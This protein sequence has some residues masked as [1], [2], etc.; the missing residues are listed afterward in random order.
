MYW[1]QGKLYQTNTITLAIDEPGLLYGATIF[2]T[3]RVYG[4]SLSHRLTHWQAHGD[5]LKQSIM[6]LGWRS[7][8]WNHIYQGAVELSKYFPVVR[9]TLFPDGREWI[10]GR[11]LP[12]DLKTKQQQGIVATVAHSSYRRSLPQLKTGNYLTPWLARKEAIQK[13]AGEA[14][15]T[16]DDG[17]WLETSTGNLWGYRD[18]CWWTPQL[19]NILPGIIREYLMQSISV[20]QTVWTPSFVA[21]IKTLAYSNSVV[22]LMPIHTVITNNH[23]LQFNPAHTSLKQL[24]KISFLNLKSS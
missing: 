4:G 12:T 24:F 8:D 15:L 16:D 22:E 1:Y 13:S 11:S 21:E 18:G 6:Q 10:T 2:T 19:G 17:N 3:V 7:P 14:I 20:N 9:I 5:R 23:Q